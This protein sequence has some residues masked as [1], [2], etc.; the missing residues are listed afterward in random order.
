MASKHSEHDSKSATSDKSKHGHDE[1]SAN[2]TSHSTDS[3]QHNSSSAAQK[4]GSQKSD[5]PVASIIDLVVEEHIKV[6]DQFKQLQ[7]LS[8]EDGESIYQ[9]LCWDISLHAVAEELV[10]EKPPFYSFL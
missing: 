1:K 6:K 10:R 2:G 7:T 9:Q 4:K 8:D 3:K 5:K